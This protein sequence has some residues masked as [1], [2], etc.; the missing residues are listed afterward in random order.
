MNA[1]LVRYIDIMYLQVAPI[2]VELLWKYNHKVSVSAISML[3]APAVS[4]FLLVLSIYP[5]IAIRLV[6]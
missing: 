5:T 4:L 2:P 1:L 6:L 3:Q